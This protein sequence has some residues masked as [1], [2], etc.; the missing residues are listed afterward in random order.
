MKI[1]KS[2]VKFIRLI[3]KRI[4]ELCRTGRDV[5]SN[6]ASTGG[7]WTSPADSVKRLDICRKCELLQSDGTCDICTCYVST[8]VKFQAAKCPKDKW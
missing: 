4:V 6:A 2:I 8:K 1:L 5:A 3:P 7:I